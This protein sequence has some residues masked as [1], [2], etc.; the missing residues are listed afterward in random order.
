MGK[1]PLQLRRKQLRLNYW[2][3]L[4]GQTR[5]HSTY[6]VIQPC[7]EQEAARTESSVCV[8]NG[9]ARGAGIQGSRFARTVP[10]SV[11]PP[12]LFPQVSQI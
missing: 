7:W 8:G 12:W 1:M 3:N 11:V 4:K 6:K 2:A 9:L 10:L 5:D